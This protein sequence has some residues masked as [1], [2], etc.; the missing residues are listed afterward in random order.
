MTTCT[1]YLNR[2]CKTVE[3]EDLKVLK[4]ADIEEE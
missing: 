1:L 3:V 2:Q 4:E